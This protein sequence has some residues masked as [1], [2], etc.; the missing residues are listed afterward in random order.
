MGDEGMNRRW[1]D[2]LIERWIGKWMYN[3][4]GMMDKLI[5]Y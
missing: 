4:N 2:I 1:I 5:M 3:R